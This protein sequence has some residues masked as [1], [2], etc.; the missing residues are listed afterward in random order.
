[1]QRQH[2]QQIFDSRWKH[3]EKTKQFNNF[4][5]DKYVLN[6]CKLVTRVSKEKF[7]SIHFKWRKIRKTQSQ[8]FKIYTFYLSQISGFFYIVFYLFSKD[9]LIFHVQDPVGFR[10]NSVTGFQGDNYEIKKIRYMA[11]D[12]TVMTVLSQE[13]ENTPRTW[14]FHST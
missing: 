7:K 8:Y 11:C 9:L 10:K 2:H 4:N 5:K 12:K 14:C 1:M 6:V 13:A 3:W